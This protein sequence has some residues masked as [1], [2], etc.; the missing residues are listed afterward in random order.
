MSRNVGL[1]R[2]RGWIFG[3]RRSARAV[4]GDA[5]WKLARPEDSYSTSFLS[6]LGLVAVALTGAI[7]SRTS[8]ERRERRSEAA[9]PR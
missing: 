1:S 8:M 7:C 6:F 4:D 2:S 5:A 9:L 3:C